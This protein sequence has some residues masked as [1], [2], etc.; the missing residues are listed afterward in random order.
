M[1][2]IMT[3]AAPRILAKEGK[4][5][6]TAEIGKESYQSQEEYVGVKTEDTFSRS[7]L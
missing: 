2:P 5:H 4:N 7:H 6:L 1:K 3:A